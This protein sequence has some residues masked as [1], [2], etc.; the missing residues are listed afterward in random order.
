MYKILDA[1]C[2]AQCREC[3]LAGAELC[4]AVAE[5]SRTTIRSLQTRKIGRDRMIAE[6]GT[7]PTFFGVVRSGYLRKEKLRDDGRRTL[8]GLLRPGDL[9]IGTQDVPLEYSLETATDVEL[10]T[11]DITGLTRLAPKSR[12]I[13]LMLMQDAAQQRESM[14]DLIWR[15]GALT[16]RERIIDFIVTSSEFMPTEPQPDGGVI[17]TINLSRRDWA[18]LSSSSVESISRTMTWLAKRKL[19]TSL[20]AD[21]YH[22]HDMDSL[23]HFAGLDPVLPHSSGLRPRLSL[24]SAMNTALPHAVPAARPDVDARPLSDAPLGAVVAPDVV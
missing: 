6:E 20:G 4:R 5:R 11:F 16:S 3:V 17:V 13:R 18:D 12:I 2:P 1:D 19:V 10:C 22:I 7:P 8:L 23:R 14:L 15:R 9:I 21:R 24:L